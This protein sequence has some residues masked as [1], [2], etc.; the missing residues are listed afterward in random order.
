M[1]SCMV[2]DVCFTI[3]RYVMDL[4]NPGQHPVHIITDIGDIPE[5][6]GREECSASLSA[7]KDTF[8]QSC[9]CFYCVMIAMHTSTTVSWWPPAYFL[10]VLIVHHLDPFL[11]RNVLKLIFY[12]LNE[13]VWL[14]LNVAVLYWC[15]VL[16]GKRECSIKY[17]LAQLPFPNWC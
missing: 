1:I 11:T 16:N 9:S 12:F 5:T 17:G 6:L 3:C 4:L 7:C 8:V 14:Y 2:V 10:F 13:Y 15:S